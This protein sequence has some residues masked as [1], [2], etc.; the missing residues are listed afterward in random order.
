MKRRAPFA[1]DGDADNS[2]A[3]VGRKL[4]L[5]RV[6]ELAAVAGCVVREHALAVV[7]TDHRCQVSFGRAP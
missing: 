3:V 5:D 4:R 1:N 7:H 6:T 2:L